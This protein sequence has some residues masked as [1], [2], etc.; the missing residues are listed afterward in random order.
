MESASEQ[1]FIGVVQ[2]GYVV[3]TLKVKLTVV[4]GQVIGLSCIGK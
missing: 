2:H 3:A 1:S 4:D